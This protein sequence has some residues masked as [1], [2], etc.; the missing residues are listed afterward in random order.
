M[1]V[2]SIENF[3]LNSTV[4]RGAWGQAEVSVKQEGHECR[5]LVGQVCECCMFT[6]NIALDQPPSQGPLGWIRDAEIRAGMPGGQRGHAS[7][8]G[9][10]ECACACEPNEWGVCVHVLH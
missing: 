5:V 9:M 1:S 7:A 4:S 2:Y 8:Q 3:K 6:V 10:D